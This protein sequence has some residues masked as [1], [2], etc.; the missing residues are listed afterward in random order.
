[1]RKMKKHKFLPPDLH[2]IKTVDVAD[3]KMDERDRRIA[4]LEEELKELRE[5]KEYFD[6]LYGT[7]LEIAGWHLSSDLEPFDNF[8]ESACGGV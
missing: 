3:S 4:E 1:M 7:G 6:E 8:Y 5:F 2:I